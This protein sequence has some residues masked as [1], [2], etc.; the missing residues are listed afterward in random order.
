MTTCRA[1]RFSRAVMRTLP[2]LV[3]LLV[4]V[5]FAS[6]AEIAPPLTG[7]L[8]TPWSEDALAGRGWTEYPRP[9]LVRE[10][11]QNLNG[12]WDYAVTPVARSEERRVGKEC[13]SRC[14]PH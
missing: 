13:R 4:A 10:R 3:L 12:Q 2:P 8:P 9:Q 14:A 11:W 6:A 1:V 7:R 5:A